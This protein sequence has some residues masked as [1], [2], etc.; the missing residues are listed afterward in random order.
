MTNINW[1]GD[2]DSAPFKSR[3]DDESENLI[4]A[5]TDAGTALFEWDGSAWQF[6]GPVEMNDEDVSGIGSLTA[7]GGNFDSVTTDA[8]DSNFAYDAGNYTTIQSALNAA[9]DDGVAL[10]TVPEGEYS[11]AIVIPEGVRLTGAN[12][13]DPR[14]RAGTFINPSDD[15][16]PAVELQT[17]STIENIRIQNDGSGLAVDVNGESARVKDCY[18][19]SAIE[20]DA[21]YVRY[22]G[23]G[24]GE[25]HEITLSSDTIR[26]VVTGNTRL[27]VTDNGDNTIG[28]NS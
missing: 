17:L 16:N 19:D 22:I 12:A 18:F 9:A 21:D 8:I 1:N 26:G 11:E 15:N 13:D 7:A 4:L 10:V 5:E 24:G 28:D 20:V 23:N 3:F 2:A 27:T 6:R 25:N 14:F